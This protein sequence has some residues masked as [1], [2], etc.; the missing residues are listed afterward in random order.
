MRFYMI[1]KRQKERAKREEKTKG[2]GWKRK[3]AVRKGWAV[4]FGKVG[5]ILR[6]TWQF[7]CLFH[8]LWPYSTFSLCLSLPLW[9]ALFQSIFNQR[10]FSTVRG[11]ARP[12][13]VSLRRPNRRWW[14]PRPPPSLLLQGQTAQS[15][16]P[17]P[18]S[19][20]PS[21]A[22]LALLWGHRMFKPSEVQC[23]RLWWMH[24]FSG[25]HLSNLPGRKKKKSHS[26]S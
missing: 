20:L 16:H 1:V 21:E 15:R 11:A 4:S 14:W 18:D 13:I 24:Y 9:L 7:D 6:L 10:L 2:E 22:E 12:V 3:R 19:S 25:L 5:A 8:S 23:N 17:D 26:I